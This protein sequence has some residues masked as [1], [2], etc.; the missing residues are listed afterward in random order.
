MPRPDETSITVPRDLHAKIERLTIE[1]G[2]DAGRRITM[3]QTLTALHSLA[4]AGDEQE[5]AQLRG[6][7]LTLVPARGPRRAG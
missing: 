5:R 7:L 2:M 6:A 3:V 4:T 1:L